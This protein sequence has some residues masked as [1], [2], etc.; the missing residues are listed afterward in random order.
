MT[1][2][3]GLYTGSGGLQNVVVPG[4]TT[5][6]VV[7]TW[8][9]D[10]S[11]TASST[12]MAVK[13]DVITGSDYVA[14]QD[15]V[16]LA[17]G[18]T[19]ISNG[20]SVDGDV[21]IG[22]NKRRYTFFALSGSMIHTGTY[23]GN[24]TSQVVST[25]SSVQSL[26]IV[27]FQGTAG[28]VVKFPD[29][30]SSLAMRF[31]N[32]VGRIQGVTLNVTGTNGFTVHQNTVNLRGA[33][34]HYA[35]FSHIVG[36]VN[37]MTGSSYVGNGAATQFITSPKTPKWIIVASTASMGF[38]IK[39]KFSGSNDSG[40]GELTTKYIYRQTNGIDIADTG[41][42]GFIASSSFNS[43]NIQYHWLAGLK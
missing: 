15:N 30:S 1:T 7:L 40:V 29:M 10:I 20:F 11:N 38:S 39:D 16:S 32:D 18:L 23:V 14:L 26:F 22:E 5:P 24:G 21:S 33:T 19:M 31:A 35:A 2:N 13:I 34:Y 42:P 27:A 12:G 4:S 8:S 9:D 3:T 17:T 37:F 41:T 28:F 25:P 6:E 36:A 43:N